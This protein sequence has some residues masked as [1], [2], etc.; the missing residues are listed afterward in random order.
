MK[1]PSFLA[2]LACFLR[3]RPFLM[4]RYRIE[5]MHF[6]SEGDTEPSAHSVCEGG[7]RFSFVR[8]FLLFFGFFSV[9][10]ALYVRCS[11]KNKR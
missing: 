9:L 2:R 1:M 3:R 6:S 10:A 11:F 7:V 4:L 8:F 5:G